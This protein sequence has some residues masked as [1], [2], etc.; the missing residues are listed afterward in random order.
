MRPL[1]LDVFYNL[2]DIHVLF[3]MQHFKFNRK[4]EI[5]YD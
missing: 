1:H 2:S 5:Q 3:S 4:M